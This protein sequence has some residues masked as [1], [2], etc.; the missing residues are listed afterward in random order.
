MKTSAVL[1][2]KQQPN[3]KLPTDFSP[4]QPHQW[5]LEAALTITDENSYY[6]QWSISKTHRASVDKER[7]DEGC[8]RCC[9]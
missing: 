3:S 7:I 2:Q 5:P 4:Q 6:H 9:R 1:Q 8:L